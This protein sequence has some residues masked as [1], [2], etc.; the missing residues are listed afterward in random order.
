VVSR[1]FWQI[2][3]SEAWRHHSVV[4]VVG[5]SGA[6]KTQLARSVVDQAAGIGT[7][8]WP[9]AAVDFLDCSA[10]RTRELLGEPEPFL[11]AAHGRTLVLD[12]AGRLGNGPELLAMAA[13]H[14]PD[15]RILATATAP[16]GAPTRSAAGTPASPSP[17]PMTGRMASVWLTPMTLHDLR[18]FGVT[19]LRRRMLHGGLP[20]FLL[21]DEPPGAAIESWVDAFWARDIQ[22]P[23]HLERAAPFRRLF[24]LLMTQSGSMFEAA[25][26]AK[27]CGA[28][29]TTVANYLAVLEAAFAM[30][31]V[32]PY[33]EGGR[34]EIV[35]APKVYGFDTGFVCHYRGAANLRPADLDPLWEHLVLN[36]LHAHLGRGAI[37]YWRTKHGT[38]VD[39][40]LARYGRAPVAVEC[41]W[42][43][44]G[45]EPAGLRSF[46]GAYPGT[47]SFVVTADTP[48]GASYERDFGLL[49]VTFASARDLIR[50]C[51][52]A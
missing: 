19:D 46:R 51:Q 22:R 20:E 40:V 18:E 4:S 24:E 43:A 3:V 26:L 1:L 33:A 36:E 42:S 27:P 31:V 14:F 34:A 38:E 50:M 9:K 29:R 5:V 30:H 11:R 15:V 48:D 28:S 41:C 44:D 7:A 10:P 13:T 52:R 32:R 6:G 17:A 35:S 47:A 12:Q 8:T 23:F 39:F 21:A 49:R 37:R 2:R 16:V 45:F 25:K